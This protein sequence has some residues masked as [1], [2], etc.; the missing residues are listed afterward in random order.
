MKYLSIFGF[1]IKQKLKTMKKIYLALIAGVVSFSVKSQTF[2]VRETSNSVNGTDAVLQSKNHNN[3]R[4]TVIDEWL[5]FGTQ[6][7]NL[8][9]I[10]Q[11]TNWGLGNGFAFTNDSNEIFQIDTGTMQYEYTNSGIYSAGKVFPVGGLL[12][13]NTLFD[14]AVL[15]YDAATPVTIDSIQI[16]GEYIKVDPATTDTLVVVFTA[17]NASSF[18]FPGFLYDVDGD[19]VTDTVYYPALNF[20]PTTKKYVDESVE[21]K[22]PL[23]AAN[24]DSVGTGSFTHEVLFDVPGSVTFNAGMMFGVSYSFKPGKVINVATDTLGL[25]SNCFRPG[26]AGFSQDASYP[27]YNVNDLWTSHILLASDFYGIDASPR[28]AALP[29]GYQRTGAS[30]G[31]FDECLIDIK[32]QQNNNLNASIDELENGA[33]LF[34]NFP[35]PTTGLTTIKYSL[36]N[37]ATVAFEVIDVTG[38]TVYTSLE[39]S[40]SEGTH[41]INLDTRNFRSGVYFYSVAVNGN[42]LTKKLTVTK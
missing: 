38:K 18:S 14:P 36:E 25:N 6:Y 10:T 5:D 9:G 8:Y 37:N 4:A 13:E 20:D 21:I 22:I 29:W 26:F 40:K 30:L 28:T 32:V 17:A 39:G 42:K 15:P 31:N 23:T 19:A 34:Q 35:N 24:Y 7:N 1:I 2:E 11:F 41:T 16:F 27:V 3:S 12:Y 33:K